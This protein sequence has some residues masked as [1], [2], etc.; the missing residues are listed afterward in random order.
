MD[1]ELEQ[2]LRALLSKEGLEPREGDLERFGPLIER[3]METLKVLRSVEVGD[4]EIAGTFDPAWK[5]K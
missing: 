1:R 5:P 3:Y 2:T 4:E